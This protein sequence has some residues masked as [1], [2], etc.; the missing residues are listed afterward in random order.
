MKATEQVKRAAMMKAVDYLLEDPEKNITKIMGMI[1]KVA[2]ADLF[3]S[4]RD[5]IRNAMRFATQSSPR[6]TG[7]S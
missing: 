6:T 2:P 3:D 4:Q 5:A 1:D 7:T